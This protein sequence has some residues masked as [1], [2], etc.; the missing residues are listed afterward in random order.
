MY[1]KF[2]GGTE[3]NDEADFSV[4]GGGQRTNAF[5]G[6]VDA[7]LFM[8]IKPLLELGN[9]RP[10][11]P[12]D[13]FELEENDKASNVYA[14][15]TEAW[16]RQHAI[17]KEPSLVMA[18]ARAFGMPFLMAGGLKLI[19]DMLIFVGPYLLNKII[20]FLDDPSEPVENGLYYVLGLFAAN[21]IMSLCLRQYFFWCY[22]V[23]M[24]LRSAVIT[25]VYA[26]ALKISVG[27]MSRRSVGEISNLMS[28]DSTRLQTLTSYLHAI[29]YSFIQIGLALY[30]LWGQLGVACLGG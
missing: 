12:S 4:G 6:I 18:Y 2:D 23:G 5:C 28:V 13:L 24:R 17:K 7:V 16:Q 26:K 29:W 30:F 1:A 9:K 14:S 21:L 19:H 22:R 3:Q 20:H 11:D 15:F 25:S 8:W 10:L 27:V